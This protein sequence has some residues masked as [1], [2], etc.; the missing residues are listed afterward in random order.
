M[1]GVGFHI[2]NK[3]AFA[4]LPMRENKTKRAAGREHKLAEFEKIRRL[5]AG[6][7]TN[8]YTAQ[9]E[10]YLSHK[11]C[12]RI[13][14][15]KINEL[16]QELKQ[17]YGEAF[18]DS[19]PQPVKLALLD[20]IYHLGYS[21]LSTQWLRF[22]AAVR[23]KDWVSAAEESHR[24]SISQSRNTKVKQLLRLGGQKPLSTWQK[25]LNWCGITEK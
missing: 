19:L 23:A 9:C 12:Q 18:Y 5:P 7:A 3:T 25:L 21:Q 17:L 15:R 1:I 6:Y 22:N 20:M 10:L 8:F 24:K 11:A 16:R 14:L 4:Q 2:A 13:L